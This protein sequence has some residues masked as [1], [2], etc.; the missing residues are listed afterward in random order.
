M[1]NHRADPTRRTTIAAD[2]QWLRT[3]RELCRFVETNGR[4]PN[5]NFA[6]PEERKLRS[7]CSTQRNSYYGLG[8]ATMTDERRQ[9]LDRI[10]GWF[11]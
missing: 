2:K 3:Y 8:T 4:F 1:S 11:W 10:P 9:L 5:S 7:W 6:S